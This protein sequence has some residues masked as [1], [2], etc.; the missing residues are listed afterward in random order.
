MLKVDTLKIKTVHFQPGPF[1]EPQETTRCSNS[2]QGGKGLTQIVERLSRQ[3][4]LYTDTL[5][6]LLLWVHEI[7]KNGMPQY[8][9]KFKL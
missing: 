5:G 7:P 6:L 4:F 9:F 8:E 2:K 3:D 1:P